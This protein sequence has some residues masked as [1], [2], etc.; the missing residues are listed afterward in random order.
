MSYFDNKDL[1]KKEKRHGPDFLTYWIKIS[2]FIVW[3]LLGIFFLVTD[4][5]RP[6]EATFFDHYFG[7]TV[8]SFWDEHM[9][10]YSF[11]IAVFLFV[12]SLIS[13]V[14]NSRRLKREG[15]RISISLVISLTISVISII[16]YIYY[17]INN[18]K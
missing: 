16:L 13:L 18:I 7:T 8:R 3:L 11:V 5:A 17:Y 12:F 6:Q 4:M 15:D 14:I 9:L 10:Y 2:S 1:K